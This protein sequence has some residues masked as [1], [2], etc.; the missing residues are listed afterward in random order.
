VGRIAVPR[1]VADP[2][3]L[4]DGWGAWENGAIPDAGDCQ[5]AQADRTEAPRETCSSNDFSAMDIET[6]RRRPN[7]LELSGPAKT[8]S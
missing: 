2:G 3:E 4:G 1:S 6:S 5:G 7:G 8:R